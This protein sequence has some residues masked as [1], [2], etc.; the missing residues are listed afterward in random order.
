MRLLLMLVLIISTTAQA[1]TLREDYPKTYTVQPGDTL[2][3]IASKYLHKPWEWKALWHANPTIKNPNRLYPG[4]ILKLSFYHKR[5]FLKVLPNGTVKLTPHTRVEAGANAIPPVPLS[6]IEPFLN[7]SWVFDE[8]R[9][10]DA[11]YIVDYLGERLR[12]GQGDQVYVKCLHP[13]EKLP[14]GEKLSY[15][16]FRPS[17]IYQEPNTERTL[18]YKSRLV[19][20]GELVQ[21]GDPAVLLLTNIT[22]GVRLADRVIPNSHPYFDL[23]FEPQEPNQRLQG[24]IIDLL[25][26]DEQ[27]ATGYVAVID[28]G[29]DHNLEPGDVLA[30]YTRSKLVRDPINTGQSINIP[31]ERIGEMMIFRTF[32]HTSFALVINSTKAIHVLDNFCNP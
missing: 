24:S 31:P 23:Y 32:T 3:S 30:I 11:P 12:A 25:G 6:D 10:Q 15:A 4:D 28:R 16:I 20:Y 2:W 1:I 13:S 27:G 21:G 18:G 26:D 9:L 19:G 5:P 7:R 14:V 22:T 8:N 29:K 17:G